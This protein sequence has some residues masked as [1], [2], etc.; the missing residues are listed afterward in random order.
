MLGLATGVSVN[1]GLELV[2]WIGVLEL[3]TGASVKVEIVAT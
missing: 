1:V 3:A 2:N